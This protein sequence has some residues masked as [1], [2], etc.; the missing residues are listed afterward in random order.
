MIAAKSHADAE[1]K[2]QLLFSM[3]DWSRCNGAKRDDDALFESSRSDGLRKEKGRRMLT[4]GPACADG[5]ELAKGSSMTELQKFAPPIL[6]PSGRR[7]LCMVF[8][9][10]ISGPPGTGPGGT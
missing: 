3:L 1:G 4:F 7:L 6:S 2:L 9:W 5:A 10:A 8:F